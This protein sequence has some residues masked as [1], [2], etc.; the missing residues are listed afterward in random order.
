MIA[1]VKRTISDFL[2]KDEGVIAAGVDAAESAA[3]AKKMSLTEAIAYAFEP[4]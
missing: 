3:P 4:A 2:P 1:N